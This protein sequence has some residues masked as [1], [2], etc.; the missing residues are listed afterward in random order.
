MKFALGV[1][2]DGRDFH[3][4]E[5]QPNGRTVQACLDAALSKVADHPV[6]TICAG[7]TDA[8]VHALGQVVHFESRAERPLSAWVFGANRN[9]PADVCVN[10]SRCVPDEFHARF[11]AAARRYRYLILNRS[12]R[13]AAL[14]GRAS[15]EYRPLVV[16]RMQTAAGYLLGEHDFSAFRGAGCQSRSAVRRI[17]RLDVSRHGPYVFSDISANAFLLHM[18]RNI[19]GVLMDT[20]AGKAPVDWADQV[21]R[22]AD[23]R[24]GGVTA[25]PDGLYLIQVDYPAQYRLPMVP[26]QSAL[27]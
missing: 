3:G 14:R 7:R 8:G 13:P 24:R 16:E 1:E 26:P 9:L 15:W 27:W 2:Y 6:R 20:G 22:A 25:P 19:A 23:R 10:W 11:S 21:L 5:T 18:V 12:T 4:F 17:H